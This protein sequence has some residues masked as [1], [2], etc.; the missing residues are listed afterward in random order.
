MLTSVLPLK[1]GVGQNIATRA[2][3]TAMNF[4]LVLISTFPVHSPSYIFFLFKFSPLFFSLFFFPP[5]FFHTAF[6]L[7]DAGT[8]VGS[9]EGRPGMSDVPVLSRISGLSFDSPFLS[10]SCFFLPSPFALSVLSFFC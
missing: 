3:S 2:L 7:A 9:P 6:V 5:F 4:F 10:L 1:P 8:C